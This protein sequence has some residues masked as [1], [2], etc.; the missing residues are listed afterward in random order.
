MTQQLS[1]P[2]CAVGARRG[3][4]AVGPVAA[5]VVV[6]RKAASI[7]G[8]TSEVQRNVIGERI[9][10]LPREQRRIAVPIHYELGDDHVVWIT[11]DR[12]EPR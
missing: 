10:G 11:I 9:L 5:P 6:D 3:G 1:R 12:P 8:G 2:P 4:A 7:A